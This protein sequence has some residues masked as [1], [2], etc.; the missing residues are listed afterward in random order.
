M[1]PAEMDTDLPVTADML[2]E[3][4]DGRE[5][6]QRAPF[7]GVEALAEALK[8]V[9]V[10]RATIYEWS[11][12]IGPQSCPRY[13]VGRRVVFILN[14]VIEWVRTTKDMRAIGPRRARRV[15]VCPRRDRRH[16]EASAG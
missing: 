5:P 11:R 9:G 1:T 7:I 15:R 8:P 3:A 12:A 10:T 13:K 2:E 4:L 16:S 14:E 6:M